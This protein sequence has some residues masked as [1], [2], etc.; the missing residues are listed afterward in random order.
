MVFFFFFVDFLWPFFFLKIHTGRWYLASVSDNVSLKNDLAVFI[1]KTL[2][3]RW[4]YCSV[5]PRGRSCLIYLHLQY[6]ATN[7]RRSKAKYLH[8]SYK[9]IPPSFFFVKTLEKVI[10]LS[11]V[12]IFFLSGSFEDMCIFHVF[13]LSFDGVVSTNKR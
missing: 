4:G 11:T 3:F 1:I 8:L 10:K 2:P 12:L 9:V 6:L 5:S 7:W 13:Q